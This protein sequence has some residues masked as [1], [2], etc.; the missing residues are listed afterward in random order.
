M[1]GGLCKVWSPD[2]E[3]KWK[4]E[5]WV[6]CERVQISGSR[7][8][9][10]PIWPASL[11]WVTLFKH[12]TDWRI[13]FLSFGRRHNVPPCAHGHSWAPEHVNVFIWTVSEGWRI[14]QRV[15]KVDKKWSN[16]LH[17][18]KNLFN[19]TTSQSVFP[20]REEPGLDLERDEVGRERLSR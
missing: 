4:R 12:A 14:L 15:I 9:A 7:T 6:Y 2:N 3:S 18:L 13:N 19:G 8:S 16:L 20:A 11:P 5:M 1:G 17:C 10:P